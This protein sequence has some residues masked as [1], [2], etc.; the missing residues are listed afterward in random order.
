[1]H[2]GNVPHPWALLIIKHKEKFIMNQTK[3]D[4]KAYEWEGSYS[5]SSTMGWFSHLSIAIIS[6]PP[7]IGIISFPI[8]RR[9]I[10]SYTLHS[11]YNTNFLQMPKVSN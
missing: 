10:H 1:L 2:F 11:T 8:F 3:L 9:E 5:Y 7:L 4:V 6:L